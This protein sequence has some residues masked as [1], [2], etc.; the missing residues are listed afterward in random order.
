LVVLTH[1]AAEVEDAVY[2]TFKFSPIRDSAGRSFYFYL[3]AP[4]AKHDNAITVRGATEDVY[5][6]GAAVL[7][8]VQSP[9]VR[10]LA[11]RLEYDPPLTDRIG[12]ILDRLPQNKPAIWGD[13]WLYILLAVAYLA[14]LYALFVRAARTSAFER[15]ADES[16]IQ[17]KTQ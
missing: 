10:D 9:A 15:Q 5:S 6:D 14:L 17:E 7:S 1:D 4:Q 13:K 12:L 2:H 3:E 11:F 16:P 8:G